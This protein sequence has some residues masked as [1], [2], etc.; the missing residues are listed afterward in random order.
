MLA[1]TQTVFDLPDSDRGYLMFG[2]N[3]SGTARILY[4]PIDRLCGEFGSEAHFLR[5]LTTRNIS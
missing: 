3:G 5:F 1:P 2:C 4:D